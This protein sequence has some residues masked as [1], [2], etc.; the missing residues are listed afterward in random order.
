MEKKKMK[1]NKLNNISL[2]S[3]EEMNNVKGGFVLTFILLTYE[4]LKSRKDAGSSMSS[5]DMEFWVENVGGIE[6]NPAD[7]GYE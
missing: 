7:W 2:L 5:E 3:D 6:Y 1:Y 4:V